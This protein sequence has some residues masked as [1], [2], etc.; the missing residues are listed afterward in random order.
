MLVAL[1]FVVRCIFIQSSGFTTDVGT[2]QAWATELVEG[3]FANFYANG[4]FADYPPGYFY[5]L[6]IVGWVWEAFFKAG[7]PGEQVLRAMVKL[8]AI[9]ADL[10]VGVLLYAIARRFA[11]TTIALG[12]AALYLLNPAI[13]FNSAIYG[14]VDSVSAGFALLAVFLLFRSDDDKTDRPS[15]YVVAAWIALAYSLLIKPQAAVLLPLFIA[16]AFAD[17]VRRRARLF[18]SGIGILASLVFAIVLTE[19][20]HPSNPVA[21]LLWLFERYQYGSSVYAYNTVN[22]F[23]L[24][25][26]RGPFW[27]ADNGPGAYILFFPQYIWG[28]GLVLAAVALVVWRYVQDRSQRAFLEGCAVATLAFFILSTRMHERYIF[29]GVVFAIACVPLARRYIWGAV[30]LSIV[31]Y[32]NL[33]YAIQYLSA[34]TNHMPGVNTQNLW[35]VGT[36]LFSILAVLTFFYLGYMYL[37]MSP[38]AEADAAAKEEDGVAETAAAPPTK[39]AGVDVSGATQTRNWFD[40]GEGL[41]GLKAPLDYIVMAAF[42]VGNFILSFI[43]Y[44]WPPDKVFDEIYFARAGEEYLQNLRIYE[45]TH[46]P[47]TKLLVTFSIMLFGGM[48]HGHGL[49]GWQGLNAIVGHM[50]D[51][52]NSYGWRFVDIIF[53]SLVVMLLFAFAKR[54]T[55][56]TLFAA[57]TALSPNRRRHA[58]RAIAHRDA[59]RHRHL[60]CDRGRLRI[61]SILDI[62]ASRGTAARRGSGVGFC[63]C[64]LGIGGRGLHRGTDHARALAVRH[65]LVD[66]HRG[67]LH[68]R[69]LSSRSLC[70]DAALLGRRKTRTHVPGRLASVSRRRLDHALRSRRRHDRRSRK[71]PTRRT[72]PKREGDARLPR[73]RPDDRLRARRERDL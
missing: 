8:P 15:W 17:P 72:F 52:D 51:G 9:L 28:I 73:R 2:F 60:L 66:R 6:G 70:T 45:N 10:G 65:T 21:A 57:V 64:G 59:R 11:S 39:L 55:G 41:T 7:D 31:L 35:G 12:T 29:D 4:H 54:I 58:F 56:S 62:L 68:V 46:P 42:G 1:G 48:P 19:P 23:N 63:G 38:D 47:L 18:A 37:G 50:P 30:A 32:A 5:I 3:G 25:A 36:S 44:W 27:Q 34:V 24:W 40:P 14:Q 13:I 16:F 33:Q 69:I 26:I 71:D 20:F 61:L 67:I 43:G 49:G 53:S 22:A